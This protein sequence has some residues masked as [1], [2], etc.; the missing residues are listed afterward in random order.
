MFET[1]LSLG[2]NIGKR[3]NNILQAIILLREISEIEIITGSSLYE[4][5]PLGFKEQE[6]FLNI[7]LKLNTRLSPFALIRKI[8]NIED[9]MG[10]TI[11][12]RWGPRIIDIDILYYDNKIVKE[13]KL[14]IPHPRIHERIFVLIPMME[15]AGDF[16]CPLTSL[17]ITDIMD[18]CKG[19]ESVVK[20]KSWEEII[21]QCKTE[22]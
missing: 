18:N 20:L 1:F 22:K 15:I 14:T 6:H 17:K 21:S 7:V 19:S 10:K 9:K 12:R 4:T 3:E 16:L 8:E 5:E 2:S 13:K 11:K